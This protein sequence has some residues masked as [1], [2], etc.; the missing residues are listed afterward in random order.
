[1]SV[2]VGS[3]ARFSAQDARG[4][5]KNGGAGEP[6]RSP[7][8]LTAPARRQ[9]VAGIHNGKSRDSCPATEVGARE[10]ASVVEKKVTFV[11][12]D[13]DVATGLVMQVRNG[14]DN[15]AG[16]R[17]LQ[18]R[19]GRDCPDSTPSGHTADGSR[20][21]PDAGVTRRACTVPLMDDGH[22]GRG[23]G[24]NRPLT[25]SSVRSEVS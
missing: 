6:A 17:R 2:A 4:R 25:S 19:V 10:P 13:T 9:V 23:P 1:M 7:G 22:P 21:S 12:H 8:T 14:K 15:E 16:T 3:T 11:E 18:L 20:T 5:A 24:Q